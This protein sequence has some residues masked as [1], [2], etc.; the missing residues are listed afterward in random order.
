VPISVRDHFVRFQFWFTEFEDEQDWGHIRA[1][2]GMELGH[3][4]F[5]PL[6][7]LLW[8][9]GGGSMELLIL[10]FAESSDLFLATSFV[11]ATWDCA[12][13]PPDDFSG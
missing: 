9:G 12:H 3:V 4:G 11:R 5:S 8:S 6:Y 2:R 1:P 10:F 7:L 13:Y